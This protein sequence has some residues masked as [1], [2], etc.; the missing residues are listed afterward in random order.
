MLEKIE[1]IIEAVDIIKLKPHQIEI[2]SSPDEI[3]IKLHIRSPKV[4]FLL[5]EIS[6]F[7]DIKDGVI[8]ES[9]IYLKFPKSM[10]MDTEVDLWGGRQKEEKTPDNI[11]RLSKIKGI[12][13]DE[14]YNPELNDMPKIL[15]IVDAVKKLEDEDLISDSKVSQVVPTD[16]PWEVPVIRL[17]EFLDKN[18]AKDLSKGLKQ[19]YEKIKPK[20]DESVKENNDETQG[21]ILN[22]FSNQALIAFD[23]IIH[24]NDE[25]VF[26]NNLAKLLFLRNFMDSNHDFK[27]FLMRTF[28]PR[29]KVGKME[30]RPY[31]YD[32]G[33]L[34]KGAPEGEGE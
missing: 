24:T 18:S 7:L 31:K 25:S 11:D 29:D 15:K 13:I 33:L 10:D 27:D 20:W 6:S 21:D 9:Y 23:D 3:G 14:V 5:K 8:S 32:L 26:V 19:T 30:K 17:G 28:V 34:E 22:D 12:L 4:N 16:M 1:K 2:I